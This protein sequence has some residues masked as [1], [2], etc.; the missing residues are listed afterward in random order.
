[1]TTDEKEKL[2]DPIHT[3]KEP[4]SGD[5]FSHFYRLHYHRIY[6][7]LYRLT[8]DSF[9]A[10]DIAQETFFRLN[11]LLE[12]LSAENNGNEEPPDYILPWLYRV[13]TNLGR[14]LLKRK[15]KFS[16]ILQ[17]IGIQH[18]NRTSTDSE[19][20]YIQSEKITLLKSSLE[21][22]STRDRILLMLY[23]DG[24]SYA[25]MA[26]IAEVKKSSVGKFLS[27][28]IQRCAN[29]IKEHENT[30]NSRTLQLKERQ[31]ELS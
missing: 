30:D 27:R 11:R 2:D 20:R 1:M 13:S 22:L 26:E 16:D 24:L 9:E 10:E 21:R 14:N 19:S 25:E 8:W 4:E 28:A 3:V 5:P 15:R 23:M 29:K 6:R 31:D 18:M 17:N 12:A 7:Y